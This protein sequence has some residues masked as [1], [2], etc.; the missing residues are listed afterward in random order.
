[1]FHLPTC[2]P[3]NVFYTSS[4]GGEGDSISS[5]I[6]PLNLY[7]RNSRGGGGECNNV[8]SSSLIISTF[9]QIGEGESLHLLTF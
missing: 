9:S 1:M 7:F 5:P 3:G 2:P 6:L 4:R 8:F